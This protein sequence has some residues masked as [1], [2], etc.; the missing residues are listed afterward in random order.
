MMGL[1]LNLKKIGGWDGD[2]L[3]KMRLNLML[4][5]FKVWGNMKGLNL[6]F[7]GEQT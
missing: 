5:Y 3:F 6:N 7:M 2:L 1:N 4:F